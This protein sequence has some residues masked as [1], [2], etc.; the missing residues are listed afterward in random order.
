MA[1]VTVGITIMEFSLEYRFTQIEVLEFMNHLSQFFQRLD[2]VNLVEYSVTR[3]NAKTKIG[4]M[5]VVLL[6]LP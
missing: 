5:W 3:H 2:N 6:Q 4:E 1:Q